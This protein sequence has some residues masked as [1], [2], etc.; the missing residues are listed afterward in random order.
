MF[1]YYIR[2]REPKFS[3]QC[4]HIF[5]EVRLYGFSFRYFLRDSFKDF[6]LGGIS[7]VLSLLSNLVNGFPCFL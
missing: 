2:I 5:T 1:G 4:N 7:F 6:S 3:Y